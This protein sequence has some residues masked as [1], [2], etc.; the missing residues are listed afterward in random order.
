MSNTIKEIFDNLKSPNTKEEFF[1]TSKKVN[2]SNHRV[3]KDFRQNFV[4]L[5]YT[6]D[7]DRNNSKGYTH[8]DVVHNARCQISDDTNIHEEVFSIIRFI[9]SNKKNQNTLIN[10]CNMV[11]DILPNR[12]TSFDVDKIIIDLE[13]IFEAQK[14]ITKNDQIGIFGEMSI[15]KSVKN[16]KNAL[17][18]WRLKSP[19]KFDFYGNST[20]LE[21]KTTMSNERIHNFRFNQ[22]NHKSIKIFIASILTKESLTGMTIKDLGIEILKNIDDV[23]LKHKLLVNIEKFNNSDDL[24]Q[25]DLDYTLKNILF[26]DSESIPKITENPI[27]VSKISF[28][29]DLSS[30]QYVDDLDNNIFEI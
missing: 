17:K 29:S 13:E 30:A 8:F 26:F 24:I 6:E 5:I 23:K 22:V 20:A 25:F 15:I 18:Y 11:L 16:Y 2:S 1:F 4:F 19:E 12:A 27:G 14:Q 3:G 10:V 28:Q 9:G 21:V 7:K